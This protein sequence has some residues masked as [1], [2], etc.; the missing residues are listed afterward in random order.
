MFFKSVWDIRALYENIHA[1]SCLQQSAG[2]SVPPAL[3]ASPQSGA[4]KR[5]LPIDMKPLI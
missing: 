4:D 3:C 5:A 2:Q 1:A